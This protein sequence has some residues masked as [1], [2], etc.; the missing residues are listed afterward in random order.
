MLTA[1]ECAERESNAGYS[2]S[3]IYSM[4]MY[5]QSTAYCHEK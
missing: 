5:F 2:K 4:I 1:T 3:T